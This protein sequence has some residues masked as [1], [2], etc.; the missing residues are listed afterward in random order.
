MELSRKFSAGSYDDI[1]SFI[2]I[3]LRTAVV[4]DTSPQTIFSFDNGIG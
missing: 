2:D 4:H 1:N 3:F